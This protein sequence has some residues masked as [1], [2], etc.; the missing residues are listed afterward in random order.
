MEG[1]GI[2]EDLDD[3]DINLLV[4]VDMTAANWKPMG[5]ARYTG[6]FDG[7][8][9]TIKYKIDDSSR[10]SNFQGLFETIGGGGKVK[11]LHVDT[12]IKVGNARMV[13]GIAGNNYGTIENC[14]VNGHVESDHYHSSK[15]ADLGG[16]VGLNESGGTVK[17]CFMSGDVK[18]TDGN[19][20][21]GSYG[22]GMT[23]IS[24]TN[25]TYTDG[26]VTLTNGDYSGT[27]GKA[28]AETA[29]D[30]EKKLSQLSSATNLGGDD[31]ININGTPQGIWGR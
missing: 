28:D 14:F 16:I 5:S 13:G 4:D 21:E 6:T 30:I 12:Y 29:A 31:D 7:Q 17:Y 20:G 11:D 8:G 18:N 9:H 24:K 26:S 25:L 1:I 19:S 15:D 2:S 27:L 22:D 23:D 3:I 10:S